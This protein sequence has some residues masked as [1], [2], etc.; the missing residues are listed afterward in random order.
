MPKSFAKGKSSLTAT[1]KDQS[2]AGKTRIGEILSKEGQITSLQ[3]DE[4]LKIQK[5]TGERLS[6]IL[7]AKG[8]I[9]PDTIISVLGRLY[10]YNVIR[11]SEIKPDSAA[12]KILPF[13]VAK[14]HMVFPLALKDDDLS[15]AMVEPTDTRVVADLHNKTKKKYPCVCGH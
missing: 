2:G 3:L 4:A 1:I 11:F 9:D 5:K 12:R 15:V 7:L 14:E 6:S 8:Y 13:E 10:N